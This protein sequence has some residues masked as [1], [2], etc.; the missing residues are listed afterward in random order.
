KWARK[1]GLGVTQ[2]QERVQWLLDTLAGRE[3][4]LKPSV[5]VKRA[6]A[7]AGL[8]CEKA[9][10]LISCYVERTEPHNTAGLMR[11]AVH[12]GFARAI[13]LGDESELA[14]FLTFGFAELEFHVRPTRQDLV[15][16]LFKVL[17]EVFRGLKVPVVVAFDQLEDLLLARRSDDAHRIAEA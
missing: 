4:G 16:A 1:L 6:A 11:R 9:C 13:L 14:N 10:E 5:P 17:M 12:Q 7:E 3:S 2:A 15:L 8:D